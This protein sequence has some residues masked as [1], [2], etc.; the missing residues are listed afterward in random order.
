[1]LTDIAPVAS[2]VLYLAAFGA[3]YFLPTSVAIL[4]DV[5]GTIGVAILNFFFGWT[6]VGWLI[7]LIIAFYQQPGIEARLCWPRRA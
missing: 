2:A 4:R 3:L 7:P 1:M 5:N 6:I